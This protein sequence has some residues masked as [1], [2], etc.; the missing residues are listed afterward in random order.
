MPMSKS[1]NSD[2]ISRRDFVRTLAAGSAVIAS[3][4]RAADAATTP[5]ADR[6]KLITFTKPFQNI[7]YERTADVVAEAGWNGI[8][9]PV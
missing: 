5:K 9:C 4:S 3:Q 1:L 6:Y 8:E 7:G 2:S